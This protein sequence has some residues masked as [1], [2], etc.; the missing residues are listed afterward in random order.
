MTRLLPCMVCLAIVTT[1]AACSSPPDSERQQAEGALNAAR[2]ADA[3][4]YAPTELQAAEAALKKYDEA[5]AQRDY[6]QALSDALDARDQAYAAVKQAGNRKAELRGQAERLLA[7]LDTLSKAA[8]ARLSGQSGPRPTGAAADRLR[9]ALR[10]ATPLLQ[11]ARSRVE[12]QDYQGAVEKLTP[13]VDALQR[14]LPANETVAR[15]RR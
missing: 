13:A 6:R 15:R 10:N 7:D 3:A 4:V 8:T 2:Q 11:E 12:H 9:E 14:E 5:V 1:G